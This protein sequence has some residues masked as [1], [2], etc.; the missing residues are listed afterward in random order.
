M[1]ASPTIMGI[2]MLGHEPGL[3][4]DARAMIAFAARSFRAGGK[5]SPPKSETPGRRIAAG[6]G[7]ARRAISPALA[8]AGGGIAPAPGLTP[9]PTPPPAGKL[10][11]GGSGARPGPLPLGGGYLGLGRPIDLRDDL[12]APRAC[13]NGV[14]VGIDEARDPRSARRVHLLGLA[15]DAG[16]D[17]VRIADRDDGAVLG[18]EA[19]VLVDEDVL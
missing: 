18:V 12:V 19:G 14:G 4:L 2:D 5:G 7:A 10:P 15:L 9:R 8:G 16:L 6:G 17:G 1:Q 3:K 13:K 11:A